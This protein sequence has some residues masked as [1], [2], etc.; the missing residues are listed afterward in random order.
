MPEDISVVGYDN[1]A[2]AE[3]FYPTLTTVDHQT[4]RLIDLAVRGLLERLDPDNADLPPRSS[5]V[6]RT[7]HPPLHR[8]RPEMR[9]LPMRP[10]DDSRDVLSFHKHPRDRFFVD[11][12]Q[13][14]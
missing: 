3:H 8:P 6:P 7:R 9:I 2:V 11:K 14:V 13:H 4:D 1:I 10:H 5:H 12:N